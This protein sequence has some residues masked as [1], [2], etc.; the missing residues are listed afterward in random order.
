MK[1]GSYSV[2]V[3][4]GLGN[5]MFQYALALS[6]RS[7][8]YSVILDVSTYD[9]LEMHNG[10][11][12]ER[13]FGINETV[14]RKQGWHMFFLRVLAKIKPKRLYTG[15]HC[16]FDETLLNKPSRFIFGCWQDERYFIGIKD[17]IHK[18]FCF[19]H[20]DEL[21]LSIA[22]E[23]NSCQAISLHI[24][25]GDYFEAGMTI[26]S[27][28]Y[29]RKAVEWILSHVK[30]AFFFLFSDDEV[31]AIKIA[32]SLGIK[33]R[34]I[35]HNHGKESYKDMYLMTQCKHNI[36]ANSSFSWWGA[37]LNQNP[38]RIVIAPSVWKES[39]K[40]FHP[41]SKNWILL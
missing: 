28:N 23:M 35:S 38:S 19:R 8:G 37:W 3:T 12:L 17:V 41:Q 2:V 1:D 25:R 14:V 29:Y 4:G 9:F 24:R 27:E 40:F 36:I 21:N 34:Y 7:T 26:I 22:K 39:N 31:E 33:Y 18:A 20:I 32:E 13:V 15:D 5:Q 11:E 30:G 10:Y 16:V 6:L